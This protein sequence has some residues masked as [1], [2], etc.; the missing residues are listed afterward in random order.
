MLFVAKDYSFL[1]LLFCIFVNTTKP[2]GASQ[3][4]SWKWA[5]A[6]HEWEYI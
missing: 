4:Q 2:D 1:L 3:D 6:G 5:W